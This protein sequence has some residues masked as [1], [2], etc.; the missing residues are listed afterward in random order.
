[1]REREREREKER[2]RETERRPWQ[3]FIYTST[4]LTLSHVKWVSRQIRNEPTKMVHKIQ[5]SKLI[6]LTDALKKVAAAVLISTAFGE[7]NHTFTYSTIDLVI[8]A[9][10]SPRYGKLIHNQT[11][12]HL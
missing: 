8:T 1:M 6:I 2:Q 3:T 7:L 5:V 10:K 9:R 12:N 11:I 4:H